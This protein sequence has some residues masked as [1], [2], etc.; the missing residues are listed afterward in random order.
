MVNQG[1][2]T[3]FQVGILPFKNIC[4]NVYVCVCMPVCSVIA[5]VV[6]FIH[7]TCYYCLSL[8]FIVE[9]IEIE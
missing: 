8:Q 7:I 4:M 3:H 6:S 5:L 2:P 9:I 1:A